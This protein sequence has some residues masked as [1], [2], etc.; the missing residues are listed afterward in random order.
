MTGQSISEGNSRPLNISLV[1]S[2][3]T[4]VSHWE[5][6]APDIHDPQFIDGVDQYFICEI[7][8]SN[9]T[10]FYFSVKNY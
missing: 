10:S 3:L 4:A 9:F 1:S 5:K 2:V 6:E 7:Q 8:L